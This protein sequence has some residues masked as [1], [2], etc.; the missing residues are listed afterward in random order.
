MFSYTFH[1]VFLTVLMLLPALPIT[2]LSH[3]LQ[4]P[5][6]RYTVKKN[7]SECAKFRCWQRWHRTKARG[8]RNFPIPTSFG[9]R[10]RCQHRTFAKLF[11]SVAESITERGGGGYFSLCTDVWTHLN[12]F[13]ILQWSTDISYLA[14]RTEKQYWR[15]IEFT[16][17]IST[18]PFFLLLDCSPWCIVWPRPLP[19]LL[20]MTVMPEALGFSRLMYCTTSA[21]V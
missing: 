10:H 4:C 2:G 21:P 7:I 13:R 15:K 18:E 12:G 5:K 14:R 19:S 3:T 11:Y 9:S 6:L 1:P 20:Y 17:H 16:H 8:S